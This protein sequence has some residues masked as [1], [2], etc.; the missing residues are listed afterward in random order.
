MRLKCCFE[1]WWFNCGMDSCWFRVFVIF[2]WLCGILVFKDWIVLFVLYFKDLVVLELEGVLLVN[3]LEL[4]WEDVLIFV[5]FI[6]F[7]LLFWKFLGVSCLEFVFVEFLL[8]GFC[9]MILIML[10]KW[11]LGVRFF[12]VIVL[13]W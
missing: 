7:L 10:V 9:W 4:Y 1:I 11:C 2:V 3:W 12:F 5:L 6:F 8:E 13:D